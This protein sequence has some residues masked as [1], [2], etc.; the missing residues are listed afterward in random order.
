[1]VSEYGSLP[2]PICRQLLSGQLDQCA[3]LSFPC[4]LY[5]IQSLQI[6]FL[7]TKLNTCEVYVCLVAM[8]SIILLWVISMWLE[9]CDINY[10]RYLT[11][12]CRLF[13][14][15]H[16][17]SFFLGEKK[18]QVS[19][20]WEKK[21]KC[22]VKKKNLS[23]RRKKRKIFKVWRGGKMFKYRISGVRKKKKSSESKIFGN[24][25]KF[26]L[27]GWKVEVKL[28]FENKNDCGCRVWA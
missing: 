11:R 26:V 14:D 6:I 7:W 9:S 19:M 1:M 13:A 25:A 17:L 28:L 16:S 24:F 27:T 22:F 10:I 8:N 20:Y 2:F 12:T 4:S 21:S 23:V 3:R 15:E 5:W 18:C